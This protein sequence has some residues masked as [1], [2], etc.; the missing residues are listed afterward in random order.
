MAVTCPRK[1]IEDEPGTVGNSLNLMSDPVP[2]KMEEGDHVPLTYADL[3]R[4]LFVAFSIG[5]DKFGLALLVV[6]F[7]HQ[8]ETNLLIPFVFGRAMDLNPVSILFFT[9][10]MSSLFGLTRA[11]LAVPAAAMFKIAIEEFYLHQC[12]LNE[13]QIAAQARQIIYGRADSETTRQ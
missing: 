4:S 2:S 13:D 6:L 9:L 12:Q 5:D 10:T 8:V 3:K 1:T 7:V 11:V